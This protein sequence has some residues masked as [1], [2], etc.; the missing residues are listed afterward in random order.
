MR[1]LTVM[2]IFFSILILIACSAGKKKTAADGV[3]QIYSGFDCGS[4]SRSA[5]VEWVSDPMMLER[6][7]EKLSNQYSSTGMP[8]PSVD[9]SKQ[10]VVIIHMGQKPTAGYSLRLASKVLKVREQTAELKLEWVEPQQG[11]MRAQIITNPCAVVTLP[12]AN[13]KGL[14]VVD[15]DEKVRLK[16]DLQGI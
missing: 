15:R 11:L 8:P 2:F 14:T 5:Y 6:A 3:V 1:T 10:R 16:I 7:F 12:A 9:F 4:Q 13:Y